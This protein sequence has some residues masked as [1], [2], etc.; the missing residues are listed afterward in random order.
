M[1][2]RKPGI[3]LDLDLKRDPTA[4]RAAALIY[5]TEK[6]SSPASIIASQHSSRNEI[7][8]VD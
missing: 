3:A 4:M 5:M 6:K 7:E 8:C 1:P 2:P